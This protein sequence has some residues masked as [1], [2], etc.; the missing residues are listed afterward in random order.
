M[1]K[2]ANSTCKPPMK[3]FAN[4]PQPELDAL[5]SCLATLKE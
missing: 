2:K 4:M 1:A 5:V 3:A